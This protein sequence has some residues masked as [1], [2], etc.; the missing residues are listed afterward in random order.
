MPL[1]KDTRAVLANVLKISHDGSAPVTYTTR[2]HQFDTAG[3]RVRNLLCAE[4]GERR[5]GKAVGVAV[6]SIGRGVRT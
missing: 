5:Y 2:L 4:T 1:D 3:T 6:R